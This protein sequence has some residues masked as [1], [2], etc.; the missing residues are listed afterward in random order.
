MMRKK[1]VNQAGALV[2]LC[3]L[4]CCANGNSYAQDQDNQAVEILHLMSAQI[5]SLDSFIITGDGYVDDRLDAGQIVEHSMDVTMRMNRPNA[6]RITNRDA[7]STK[8]IYFG[9]GVL[10]VY[11]KTENFYAQKDLPGSIN[12]AARFAVDELGI[13]APMLD[14]VSNDVAGDLLEDA[15]RVDYLGISLFRGMTYH[16]IAIRSAEVDL[17]FWVA[18]E[19]PPLPGKMAISSKWEGGSPRSVFF[20]SWDTE[21]DFGRTSFGFE[22]PE[23]STR[24]EFDLDEDQ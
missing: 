17:Q 11:S 10:T 16:H 4:I 1:S 22:L 6:M 5:A 15:E 8:E 3:V 20:F 21:P 19:G 23:G 7:E 13:D 12:E 24:I 2:R 14:F 18:A 9:E